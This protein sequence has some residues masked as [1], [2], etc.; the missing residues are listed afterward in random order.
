MC[1]FP[2][3]C[4]GHVCVLLVTAGVGGVGGGGRLCCSVPSV[5]L[6]G[7]VMWCDTMLYGSVMLRDTMLYWS[8]MLNVNGA[9]ILLQSRCSSMCSKVRT[10]TYV[11]GICWRRYILMS[12]C[13]EAWE[14]QAFNQRLGNKQT[15]RQTFYTNII[16]LYK[17][18]EQCF[19]VYSGT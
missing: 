6:Y 12:T 10:K 18:T 11:D 4:Y 8:I 14:R 7:S 5:M 16:A 19:I 17:C 2:K 15:D 1:A 9:A 3:L 13:T